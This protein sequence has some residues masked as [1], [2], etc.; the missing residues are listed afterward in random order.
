MR[1]DEY[2]ELNDL[3]SLRAEPVTQPLKPHLYNLSK[4]KNANGPLWMAVIALVVALAGVGYWSYLQQ[5]LLSKQLVATQESFAHISEQADGRI[6]AI[7]GQVVAQESAVTS[8]S[9]NIKL[10]IK[11]LEQQLAERVREHKIQQEN[12]EKLSEMTRSHIRKTDELTV[13][14]KAQTEKNNV[15]SQ[16]LSKFQHALTKAEAELAALRTAQQTLV[17]SHEQH[18]ALVT[19]VAGLKKELA[20]VKKASLDQSRLITLEQDLMLLKAQLETAPAQG[21]PLAEF[22]AYRAQVTRQL[23]TLNSQVAH[24]QQQIDAR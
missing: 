19:D 15:L 24:L 1:N 20:S 14:L 22:D 7:T 4:A 23:N 9:E 16:E 2:D 11:Q 3:P 6:Q 8:E 17:S 18:N 12:A 13:Q 5:Q 21:A 10:R